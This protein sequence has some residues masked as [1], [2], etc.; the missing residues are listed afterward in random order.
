MFGLAKSDGLKKKK[1][2]PWSFFGRKKEDPKPLLEAVFCW[3]SHLEPL[4]MA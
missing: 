4:L 1:K 2:T 3:V